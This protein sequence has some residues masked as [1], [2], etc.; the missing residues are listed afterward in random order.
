MKPHPRVERL[1]RWMADDA[2]LAT[3]PL[4][5][6]AVLYWT[7]SEHDEGGLSCLATCAVPA[8]RRGRVQDGAL[9]P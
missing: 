8:Q 4:M 2:L 5:R 9:V 3:D 7:V 1:Y 6:A